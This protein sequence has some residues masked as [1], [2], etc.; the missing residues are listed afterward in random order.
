MDSILIEAP[1]AEVPETLCIAR[2]GPNQ[3]PTAELITVA[4]G[5]NRHAPDEIIS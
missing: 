5:Y 3:A 1:E 2:S 4:N